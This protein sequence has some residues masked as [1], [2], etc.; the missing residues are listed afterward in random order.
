MA[1][2]A[3]RLGGMGLGTLCLGLVATADW[4]F[5]GRPIGWTAGGYLLLLILCVSRRSASGIGKRQRRVLQAGLIGLAVALAYHPGPLAIVLAAVGI[6]SLSFLSRGGWTDSVPEWFRRW[7]CFLGNGWKAWWHDLRL[8][9]SRRFRK[10]GGNAPASGVLRQWAVPSVLGAMFLCL[11]SAANP[12]IERMIGQAGEFLED[13]FR[14]FTE[15]LDFGRTILW[16]L[17]AVWLWALFRA[18]ARTAQAPES[19]GGSDP[20]S[21]SAVER[22]LWLFNVLFA[23]QTALDIG[24]LWGGV[25]LPEGMTYAEYA[26]RGAYPLIA[27]ALLAAVFVLVTFREGG[28]AERTR[29][30]RRLVGGWIAQNVILT[31]SA[32]WRLKL[33]TDAYGLSRWRLASGIWTG[34]VAIG[35]VWIGWRILAGRTNEWLMRV[36]AGT[37]V[38]VLYACAFVDWDGGIAWHNVRHCREAGGRGA[39]IDLAY[40]NELGE[41]SIP[42]IVWLADRIPTGP[43][44]TEAIYRIG[45]LRGELRERLADWRGW[46]FL[47]QKLEKS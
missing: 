38:V 39:P 29:R 13:G 9:I 47:R 11:F 4:L 41:A 14:F 43:I 3:W 10:L 23:I 25:R 44:R 18:R 34:L 15:H 36:N 42:A 20:Y 5:Y 17:S 32:A 6:V 1:A 19:S 40:L 12:M 45:S 28:A 8:M 30:A 27:T 37:A 21:T 35:L 2:N 7:G 33:Y 22:C 16:G 31:F 46:T 26:H 24:Y